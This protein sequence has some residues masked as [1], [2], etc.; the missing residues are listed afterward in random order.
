MQR[1]EA[2]D[3]AIEPENL[4]KFPKV[5]RNQTPPLLQP[6]V[7]LSVGLSLDQKEKINQFVIITKVF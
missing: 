2:S 4:R 1:I 5:L 3:F 6:R 7:F